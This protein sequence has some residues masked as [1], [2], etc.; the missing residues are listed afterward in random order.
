MKKMLKFNKETKLEKKHHI[1]ILVIV[2]N[3]FDIWQGLDTRYSNFYEYYDEHKKRILKKLHL[4]EHT[5]IDEHGKK[6]FISDVDIVYGDPFKPGNL[7]KTFWNKF[8][9]SLGEIDAETLNMYFGKDKSG[10]RKMKRCI[11]NANRIL[12][13]AF[14]SWIASIE[15]KNKNTDYQFGEN[16]VF[17]NFNYTDTLFTSF[18]VNPSNDFHIHGEAN[19]KKSIVF[20]HSSHPEMPEPMLYKL[21]GRFRG[22]FHVDNILYE[23]DKHVQDNIHLLIVFLALKGIMCEDI[24]NIY[25]LG[26]SFGQADIEYFEF[27]NRATK[28]KNITDDIMTGDCEED[29]GTY[30]DEIQDRIQYKINKYGYGKEINKQAE[31][32]AQRRFAEE[33]NERN[34]A[35][36]KEFYKLIKKDMLTDEVEDMKISPRAENAT[37]HISYFSDEDKTNIE[38]TLNQIGCEDY[39]LYPSIDECLKNMNNM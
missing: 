38:K 2:G 23:T 6:L 16:C 17:I 29:S 14:C 32:S 27:L 10:L 22:L 5:I 39:C 21:G 9:D 34:E 3:G 15:N 30:L 19:D 8:E 7:G 20:G 12:Q 18:G 11:K 33:Q 31:I 4:K 36:E 13:E 28:L 37:W 25:V 26:H 24:K 1:D 35:F